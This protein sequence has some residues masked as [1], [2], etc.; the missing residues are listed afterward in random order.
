MEKIC[1]WLFGENLVNNA[2]KLWKEFQDWRQKRRRAT[3]IRKAGSVLES[4]YA[5]FMANTRPNP[6]PRLWVEEIYTPSDQS[7]KAE[8]ILRLID[9]KGFEWR[10]EWVRMDF[11]YRHC[12]PYPEVA[13]KAYLLLFLAGDK[14]GQ[15]EFGH[16]PS[17][18]PFEIV[19]FDYQT[20]L[21]WQLMGKMELP[22]ERRKGGEPDRKTLVIRFYDSP[23]S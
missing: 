22:T 18:H 17:D 10:N 6:N 4:I 12:S 1:L 15:V 8:N 16:W 21:D 7:K 13:G 5:A 20:V 23:L 9:P 19:R 2:K 11:T 14:K 3:D